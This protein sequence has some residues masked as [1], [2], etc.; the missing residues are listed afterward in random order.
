MHFFTRVIVTKVR[1]VFA[2]LSLQPH[3]LMNKSY[4]I[5]DYIKPDSALLKLLIT[6]TYLKSK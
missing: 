1:T 6:Q 3:D 4:Y 2:L 5:T